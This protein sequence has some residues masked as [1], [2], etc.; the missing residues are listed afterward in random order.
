MKRLHDRRAVSKFSLGDQVLALL[1]LVGSPF[2]A[3][4]C[5]PY[6]V[7]KKVSDLNYFISAPD[8]KKSV[9]LCHGNLLKPYFARSPVTGLESS[10]TCV[11]VAVPVGQ[12]RVHSDLAVEVEEEL[13]TPDD[14]MLRGQL[15]NSE[16]LASLNEML[17]HLSEPR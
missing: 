16:P 6:A 12:V 11:A 8:W 9:Q 2:H 14:G 13:C 10:P 15:K 3:N 1:P 17:T 5:G 7:A 4:F